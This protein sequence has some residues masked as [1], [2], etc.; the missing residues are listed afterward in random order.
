[1]RAEAVEPVESPHFGSLLA[2]GSGGGGC[3]DATEQDEG[4]ACLHDVMSRSGL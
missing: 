4:K 3:G 2:G 1:M